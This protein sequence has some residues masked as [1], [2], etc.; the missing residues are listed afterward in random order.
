MQRLK[1]SETILQ[2]LRRNKMYIL[3]YLKKLNF[4]FLRVDLLTFLL[5]DLLIDRFID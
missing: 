5:I 3:M 4:I 1:I 2:E